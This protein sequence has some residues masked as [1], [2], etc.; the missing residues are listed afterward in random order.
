MSK[1]N[2][3]CPELLI[4]GRWKSG[5][6]EK[7]LPVFN[8]AS[9]ELLD[10]L[11]LAS[12]ED[13]HEALGTSQRSFDHWKKIPAHERCTRLEKGVARFRENFERIAHLLTLEQGKP[14]AEAKAEC[15]M[16]AD[17]IKWYAEEARR[18]YGRVIP[19]RLPNSRMEVFKFPVGPVAAFS[20][21][22]FPLVLSAR[23]IGGA[24]A[25]GCS[26]IV[27][28]AE[29]T[30]ASV[31]AMVDCFNQEL[32]PGVLQLVYGN[33]SEVSEILIRSSIIRKVTFTGSVPV[34][35]HLAEMAAHHLKRITLELGGHAPVIV[36]KDAD[37]DRTVNLMVQHKFR[38]AGQACLAPTRFYVDRKIYGGFIDAFSAATNSLRVGSGLSPDTQMGPVASSRRQSAVNDLISR[39][40]AAGARQVTNEVS[41]QGFFVAPTLLAD[42]PLD[43]PVMHEEPF[44]PVACAV[45][46]DQ[47]DEAIAMANSNPYGLAGYL[48]TDSAKAILSVS[49]T[50]EVGSLAVNGMG[51]SVPEAPFGGVKDSGYGSESG[52]EG[53]E[54]FLDTKFMHYVA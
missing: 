26:I 8:P 43:A 9:G 31:A 25:A 3:K 18:V 52:I 33:P 13:L 40:V 1:V 51:V 4:G 17:L 35:R 23:K 2:Y 53:M 21:W 14:L 29:E 15:A 7:R 5:Q 10:E 48:F 16:A 54:A 37:I 34:G 30:P 44:G 20:P 47:L 11:S 38:N 41:N 6:H 50:L 27:K 45:A 36:C 19:A 22:N 46:F 32:P 39:S 28:G 49:E 12:A 42:V 24:I